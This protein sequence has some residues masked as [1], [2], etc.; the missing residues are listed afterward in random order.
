MAV[1]RAQ[2]LG[3]DLRKLEPF[4]PWVVAIMLTALQLQ[5]LGFDPKYGV[6]RHFFERA[7]AANKPVIGLETPESQF[8]VFDQMSPK[9]QELMLLQTLRDLELFETGVQRLLGAWNTGDE[10]L[11]EA[12][13]LGGFKEHPELYQRVMLDRNRQW[14]P[15]LEGFLAQSEVHMVVVGAGHLVGQGNLIELLKQ[16]GYIVEQM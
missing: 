8:S 6:D 13:I 3:L 7:Q 1:E 2:G 9:Q 5:K 4:K 12:L 14:L 10:K 15:S 11:L 16:R